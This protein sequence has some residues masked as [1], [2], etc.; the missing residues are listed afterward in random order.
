MKRSEDVVDAAEAAVV[1]EAGS[2]T[3][4][5]AL[6]DVA[7][8]IEIVSERELGIAVLSVLN[9]SLTGTETDLLTTVEAEVLIGPDSEALIVLEIEALGM[10]ETEDVTSMKFEVVDVAQKEVHET[11]ALVM[12]ELLPVTGTS[13]EIM[14]EK[15]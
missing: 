15:G 3:E 12:K 14:A 9:E 1:I 8:G 6:T 10:P 2:L 11:G 4:A 13:T 7:H 5:E